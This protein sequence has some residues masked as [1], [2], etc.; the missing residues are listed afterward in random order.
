MQMNRRVE[1]L[2]LALPENALS[3]R[4]LFKREG[5]ADPMINPPLAPGERP[6]LVQ[7]VNARRRRPPAP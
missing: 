4:V 2:E 3:F 6:I 7:F 1:K 5:E